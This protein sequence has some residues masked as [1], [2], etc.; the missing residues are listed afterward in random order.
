[1]SA[2]SPSP[3]AQRRSGLRDLIVDELHRFGSDSACGGVAAGEIRLSKEPIAASL[4]PSEGHGLGIGIPGQSF[5]LPIKTEPKLVNA[6]AQNDRRTS[7]GRSIE[8]RGLLELDGELRW[9]TTVTIQGDNHAILVHRPTLAIGVLMLAGAACA[10]PENSE[11]RVD[12]ERRFVVAGGTTGADPVCQ[13][14]AR[15][16]GWARVSRA[17]AIGENV[18]GGGRCRAPSCGNAPLAPGSTVIN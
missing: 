15:G 3:I 17:N 2:A 6:F 16:A 11:C 12:R 14:Q 4:Q 1:V 9:F 8:R 18:D 13:R 5:D 7:S 10:W